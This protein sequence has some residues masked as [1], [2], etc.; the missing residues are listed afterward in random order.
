M[1]EKNKE[2]LRNWE[3]SFSAQQWTEHDARYQRRAF[4]AETLKAT[5]GVSLFS[6]LPFLAACDQQPQQLQSQLIKQQPWQDFAAV[7][8]ILFPDDGN[9]PSANDLNATAYLKFILHAADTDQQDRKFILDG[10][11]WLNQLSQTKYHNPFVV[12]ER[13]A[14]S[15]LLHEIAKSRSGERWLS[16]LLLYIF[17]ALLVDPVYGSN[18]N[19]MGWKWL[20]HQAGFPSPPP[21][22]CIPSY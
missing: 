19:G 10:S 13:K 18:P 1:S 9:G 8:N 12:L 20:E 15:E 2:I 17:E 21:E 7:Q 3:N 11:N 4:L 6:S 14:Q 22:K 16:H 5:A